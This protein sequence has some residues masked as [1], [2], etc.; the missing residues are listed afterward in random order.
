VRPEHDFGLGANHSCVATDAG[1]YCWGANLYGEL[2]DGTAESRYTPTE[3]TGLG[4]T[5]TMAAGRDFTCAVSAANQVFCWGDNSRG[6]LGQGSVSR[7]LVPDVVNF[8]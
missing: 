6:Q 4:M 3:V 8:P 5:T 1:N 2:G 7:S